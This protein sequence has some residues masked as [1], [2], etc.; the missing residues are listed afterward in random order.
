MTWTTKKE[1]RLENWL[2]NCK[3]YYWLH[4]KSR[5]YY[6]TRFNY[7]NIPII[8]ITGIL[9]IVTGIGSL[10]E[11]AQTILLISAS[12]VNAVIGALSF[13]LTAYKPSKVASM[14]DIAAKDFQ[15]LVIELEY[16]ISMEPQNRPDAGD[17]MSNTQKIITGLISNTPNIHQKAW[18]AFNTSVETGDLYKEI[19]PGLVFLTG[20]IAYN[21]SSK[22]IITNTNV[23]SKSE[24]TCQDKDIKS[25]VIVETFEDTKKKFMTWQ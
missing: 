10:I 6:E 17:F 19:D 12:I 13:Y 20:K 21:N 2:K 3:V 24:V 4:T 18:K 14:H 15:K 7:I 1:D 9:S 11:E 16:I 22:N 25:E 23:T 8:I 5:L